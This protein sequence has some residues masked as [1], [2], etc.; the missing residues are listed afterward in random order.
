MR[1]A[2]RANQGALPLWLDGMR[3][4]LAEVN[5]RLERDAEQW[6]RR[7]EAMERRLDETL[8]RLESATPLVPPEVLDA[9][10]WAADA[11]NYLDRRRTCG[12]PG[13]CP[14]PELYNAVAAH[15][16]DLSLAQFHEG[17]RGLRR[18]RAL[19]LH[20]VDDPTQMT[21][22]EFALLDGDGVF[23]LALR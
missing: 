14:L 7:L 23:Y 12:A 16:P 15:R 18:R 1:A 20:P 9:H 17:L 3:G 10:P 8:R 4:Q 21:L 11:L 13:A 2:L 5:A 22:P 19:E 6:R